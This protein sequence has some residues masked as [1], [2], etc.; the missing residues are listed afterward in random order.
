MWTQWLES[1][2]RKVTAREPQFGPIKLGF[3]QFITRTTL[4]Y[5]RE[6][7]VWAFIFTGMISTVGLS[8]HDW[9]ATQILIFKVVWRTSNHTTITVYRGNL[10]VS[11]ETSWCWPDSEYT[12]TI[13]P[14]LPFFC[15]WREKLN[16][17]RVVVSSIWRGPGIIMDGKSYQKW[18]TTT[19]TSTK[20]VIS[21]WG[22]KHRL[23]MRM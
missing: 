19:Q 2:Y 9:V 7:Q 23:N 12:S 4:L 13:C 3:W 5:H 10:N 21:V 1:L 6:G 8:P 15:Q 18:G 16:N 22:W 11:R 14:L 20:P 17:V